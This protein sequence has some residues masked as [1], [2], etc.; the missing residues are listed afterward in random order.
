ME[1]LIIILAVALAIAPLSHFVPSKR[2]RAVARMRE[3]AA[4]KG[5]F[6]EFR[7]LPGQPGSHASGSARATEGVIYYGKRLPPARGPTLPR[8]SWVRSEEAWRSTRGGDT[9]PDIL[10]D[11]PVSVLAASVD[12]GSCG[13]YWRESGG[14]EELARIISIIEAWATSL[15]PGQG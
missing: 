6:V 15:R 12:E 7:R 11:F 5:L 4:L 9:P 13:I 10:A 1:Y 2:Q 14:P 8:G 3:S